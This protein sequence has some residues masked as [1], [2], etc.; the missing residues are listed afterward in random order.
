MDAADYVVW[1]ETF[2][3]TTDLRA[4]GNGDSVINENDYAVWRANFGVLYAGGSG[5][6]AAVP[7]PSAGVVILTAW[8]ACVL[9]RRR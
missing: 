9:W 3:S 8:V 6:A 7:E 4:D 1:R 5:T 2:G